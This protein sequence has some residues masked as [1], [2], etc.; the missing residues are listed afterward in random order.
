MY[1]C[2]YTRTRPWRARE[3]ANFHF[4]HRTGKSIH[5]SI[6]SRLTALSSIAMHVP[7]CISAARHTRSQQ[8]STAD[9]ARPNAAFNSARSATTPTGVEMACL[10]ESSRRVC[11]PRTVSV[12]PRHAGG[13]AQ[14]RA[15]RSRRA[16]GARAIERGW[17]VPGCSDGRSAHS[18]RGHAARKEGGDVAPS[19]RRRR[20]PSA[21]PARRSAPPP[22]RPPLVMTRMSGLQRFRSIP[23]FCIR[24]GESRA[25]RRPLWHCHGGCECHN[26]QRPLAA[27]L[28]AQKERVMRKVPEGREGR[29]PASILGYAVKPLSI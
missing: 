12:L 26:G 14:L 17:S 22:R 6:A 10:V 18:A 29:H 2:M 28:L 7:G 13:W 8:A 23:V 3:Q 16:N 25:K 5:P 21:Q 27:P 20:R 1:E 4:Q 15:A 19:G 11:T 9:Q 24:H